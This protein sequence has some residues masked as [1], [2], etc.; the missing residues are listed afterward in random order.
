M[1]GC[2]LL[3]SGCSDRLL[4]VAGKSGV[5]WRNL[6]IILVAAF[7]AWSCATTSHA[8]PFDQEST[9]GVTFWVIS[10]VQDRYVYAFHWD[11]ELLSVARSSDSGLEFYQLP[12]GSCPLL[13]AHLI[14]FRESILDSVEI[15]F[16]RK[17][18]IPVTEIVMDSPNYRVR[19]APD[20][21]STIVQLDGYD[22]GEVPWIAAARVVRERETACTGHSQ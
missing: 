9:A 17:P 19:Y 2:L 8:P 6:G 4:L 13:H 16:V 10:P 14:Q 20:R 21:F 15:V 5:H 11:D 1:K 3:L 18:A 22:G 12:I 7:S